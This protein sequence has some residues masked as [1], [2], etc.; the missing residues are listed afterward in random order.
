[1]RNLA[2]TLALAL[3]ASPSLA[4]DNRAV[5]RGGGSSGGDS[6]SA[7]ARHHSGGSS[8]S[9]SSSS[10]GSSSGV[11]SSSSS[12]DQPLTLAQRR[13]PRA[14]TGTGGRYRN[15]GG[16]YYYPGGG[17]YSG[18]SPWYPWYYPADYAWGPYWGSYYYGYWPYGAYYSG[19]YSRAYRG[20]YR[21][22]HSDTGAIRLLVDPE[23]A[24][25]YVDGYYAGNVDDYDGLLQR[26]HLS[27]G[28]HEIMVK[29][30]GYRT[31]RYRVYVMAG[32][33]L[34]IEHDMAKGD[35]EDPLEDLTGGRGG[36]GPER[37]ISSD[38]A[39][40]ARADRDDDDQDSGEGEADASP[41]PRRVRDDAGVEVP[42][43]R[44]AKVGYLRLNVQPGDASVYVDGEF[45]GTAKQLGSLEL[46]RG[47]HRIEIV[48][49]GFRT[50][51]RDVTV[52]PG[53]TREL[54]VELAR[55]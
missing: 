51:Q 52:D 11:S 4:D 10:G 55:P 43:V 37:R 45:R 5:P 30:D 50:E 22:P 29:R 17:Y 12:D 8:S 53:Q 6:S 44:G 15:Y 28:R 54:E 2:M 40:D 31:Q 35:G 38:R 1:M 23:D 41:A 3:V 36:D 39:G 42:S 13:H 47:T 18:Y 26:L 33:S 7:G 27:R 48:R 34:K 16:G 24:K 46:G 9:G 49:P 20:S 25:V 14:G 32:T 19:G 21:S